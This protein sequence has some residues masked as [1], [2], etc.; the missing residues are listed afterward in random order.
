MSQNILKPSKKKDLIR[1]AYFGIHFFI[2]H[3]Q[4][5][6]C[7]FCRGPK[8]QVLEHFLKGSE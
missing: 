3:V 2:D 4:H 5:T 7:I 1:L 8:S 6:T